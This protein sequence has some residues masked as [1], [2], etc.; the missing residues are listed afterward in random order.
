MIKTTDFYG[1]QLAARAAVAAAA[2]AAMGYNTKTALLGK[3]CADDDRETETERR[4][5]I[6]RTKWL[7]VEKNKQM[8]MIKE[9]KILK[10]KKLGI[11]IVSGTANTTKAT[12]WSAKHCLCNFINLTC[13]AQ[14]QQ[15]LIQNFWEYWIVR[16]D[17][18]SALD[19][20]KITVFFLSNFQKER[21]WIE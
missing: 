21:W 10:K 5:M 17:H 9:K 6:N 2:A 19:E 13:R 15:Y 3:Q 1:I 11:K 20:K 16:V 14:S 7:G 12:S 18:S 8:M 4:K